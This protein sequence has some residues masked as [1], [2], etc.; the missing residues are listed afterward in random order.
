AED[1]VQDQLLCEDFNCETVLDL[2][3]AIQSM[4]EG[5]DVLGCSSPCFFSDY[6]WYKD[7]GYDYKK[8]YCE[9]YAKKSY[10]L[11]IAGREEIDT[12]NIDVLIVRKGLEKIRELEIAYEN[13]KHKEE[14]LIHEIVCELQKLNELLKD[15]DK[16]LAGFLRDT[17]D[18]LTSKTDKLNLND[19]PNFCKCFGRSQQYISFVRKRNY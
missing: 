16:E 18:I 2:K 9:Q 5:W 19:Y 10:N 7:V 11:V 17:M 8:S 15:N 13:L 6:S 4:D 12:A 14:K 3:K 1:W